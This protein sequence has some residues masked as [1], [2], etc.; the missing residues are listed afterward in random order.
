MKQLLLWALALLAAPAMSQS[1]ERAAGVIGI[2]PLPEVFGSEPCARFTPRDVP[3][4][5]S[6]AATHPLRRIHVARPW[7][8][9]K[10][11]G[12]EGLTVQ[13]STDEPAA[14]EGEL[15]TLEFGYEQPG[16]IVLRQTGSWFEVALN[17][18][19]AWVRVKDANRFL[20]VEQLFKDGLVHLRGGA[21]L[22]LYRAPGDPASSRPVRIGAGGD[23]PVKA[24][25]FRRVS[26]VLWLQVEF[27]GVDPCTE[28]K[29]PLGSTSGW[30]PFHDASG[31]PAAWFSS[32]GC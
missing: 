8:P 4:F 26:G 21:P 32:R 10:E 17:Q 1:F 15:P 3:L 5:R 20:P 11:G 6:P 19:T 31:Q 25:A 28:E 27:L 23:R 12:C 2:L 13:V 22:S 14:T 9:A 29:L 18:G 24:S 16:A 30:L 7:T